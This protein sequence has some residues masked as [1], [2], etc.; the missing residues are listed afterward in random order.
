MR[1]WNLLN[2]PFSV[3]P[4][5]VFTVPMRNWNPI[6]SLYHSCPS[7]VFTVP[8]RNWNIEFFIRFYNSLCVFTVPM[9]NWNTII[10]GILRLLSEFLQY[11]WGI[12]TSILDVKMSDLFLVFT[13]PMRNWN[14][15]I[16][17]STTNTIFRFYSTYEELKHLPV[18]SDSSALSSFYSTYEEL[19]RRFFFFSRFFFSQFLQYLWGI[20]TPPREC[21]LYTIFRFLQYLWGIETLHSY[22]I[23]YCFLLRFYSTYEELKLTFCSILSSFFVIVFTVP[24]RNWNW[25]CVGIEK[26]MTQVFT[27]PMRNWN[28]D[29]R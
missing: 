20:E 12:E 2:A 26:H 29:V 22:Y 19:K 14:W 8:M 23:K 4:D 28:L 21:I 11:L 13:V 25:A 5:L 3:F 6:Q 16:S 1:N 18:S 15:Q 9:R 10:S 7:L 24:M 27:V 17:C